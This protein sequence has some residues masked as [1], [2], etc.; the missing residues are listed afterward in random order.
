[1]KKKII[2]LSLMLLTFLIV[3]SQMHGKTLRELQAEL[4]A[5]QA[6]QA[7]NEKEQALTAAQIA[8]IKDSIETIRISITNVS[9]EMVSLTNDINDLNDQIA[10]KDAEIKK[11]INFVQVSNGESIYL[12][13]AFSA[14]DFTDFIYRVAVAEQL[15]NYNDSLINEMN[16]LIAQNK[17]KQAELEVKQKELETKQTSLGVELAKLNNEAS[18]LN[19]ASVNIE[20]AIKMQ[21]EVIQIY[22]DRGC[23]LDEDINKCGQA[24]LPITTQFYRPLIN[25]YVT[26]EFGSR[27]YYLNGKRVCNYHSGL[28]FSTTGSTSDVSVYAVATGLVVGITRRSSCGGNMVF[29]Q[30]RLSDGNTYTSGYYHLR[31]ISVS[32]GDVVTRDTE[33]GIMGGDP[34]LDYWDTCSTGAHIHIS[35]ARGLYFTDYYTWA[36]YQSNMIDPRLVINAPSDRYVWFY[37]RL[38]KYN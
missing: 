29:V 1:M 6:E 7:E 21:K 26:S 12:E 18:D 24:T 22:I 28:D 3:P 20:D 17:A 11:I 13:Y 2:I 16:D 10:I 38:S 30:H 23:D 4:E 36:T 25:G 27:C 32:V 34:N 8:Q 14:T 9:D 5:K 15:A 35:I 31:S 19:E 33:I 37:G